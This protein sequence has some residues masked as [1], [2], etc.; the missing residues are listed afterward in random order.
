MITSLI[1]VKQDKVI[2]KA[3]KLIKQIK[4]KDYFNT[5]L[6]DIYQTVSVKINTDEDDTVQD[7]IVNEDDT[8][9]PDPVPQN[10]E[11]P[12]QPSQGIPVKVEIQDIPCDFKTQ[13]SANHSVK[14]H[15]YVYS[16]IDN[17]TINRISVVRGSCYQKGI[18]S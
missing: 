1:S 16:L 10:D 12:S 11:Q 17:I 4:C 18:I 9:P 3:K 2:F 15:V 6:K 14:R 7:W 5:D 8:T 13:T